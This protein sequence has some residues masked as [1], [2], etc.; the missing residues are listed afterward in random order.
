MSPTSPRPVELGTQA[1]PFIDYSR[2]RVGWSR[3]AG[4]LFLRVLRG[5]LGK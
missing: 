4:Q 5:G 3:Q 2:G 1:C